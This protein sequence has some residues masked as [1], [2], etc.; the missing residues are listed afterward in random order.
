MERLCN[1]GVHFYQQVLFLSKLLV[2]EL[3]VPFDPVCKVVAHY[4]VGDVQHPLLLEPTPF[5]IEGGKIS[6]ELWILIHDLED[7]LDR[8]SLV[9]RTVD[10]A[11][12]LLSY[13]YIIWLKLG[14]H[15]HFFAPL[16]SSFKK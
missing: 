15:L 4:R 1:V 10:M 6:L 2:P 8:K 9:L 13:N 7:L 16:M 5:Q 3:Y 11:D 14:F 12:I